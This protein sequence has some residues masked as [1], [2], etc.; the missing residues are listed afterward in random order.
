MGS[1]STTGRG[2]F[3]TAQNPYIIVFELWKSTERSLKGF[4]VV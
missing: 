2:Q 1:V 4:F 3:E